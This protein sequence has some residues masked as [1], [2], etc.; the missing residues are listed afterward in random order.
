MARITVSQ[1]RL[2]RYHPR[3]MLLLL[4]CAHHP[5]DAEACAAGDMAACAG[6]ASELSDPTLQWQ[7]QSF[8]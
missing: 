7:L 3:S 1:G 5:P 8:A 6:A 2:G 4:A